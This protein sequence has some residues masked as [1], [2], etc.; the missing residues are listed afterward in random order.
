MLILYI[1]KI[2]SGIPS[3]NHIYYR[4]KLTYKKI[5]NNKT[6]NIELFKNNQAI[7]NLLPEKYNSN[8]NIYNPYY[9]KTM[10][11]KNPIIY[12]E[13]PVN[14]TPDNYQYPSY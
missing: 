11:K 7:N 6:P 9:Q 12:Q 10:D 1:I 5:Q 8:N 13:P 2:I 4:E 3:L 14:P